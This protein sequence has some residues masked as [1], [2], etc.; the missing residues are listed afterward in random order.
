MG[1]VF[2]RSMPLKESL[3]RLEEQI[4]R[5][6]R[7]VKELTRTLRS[8]RRRIWTVSAIFVTATAAYAYLDNQ[9]MLL[10]TFGGTGLCYVGGYLLTRLYESRIRAVESALE[11]LRER[12][13]EQI[14]LLR[15]DECFETTKKLIDKYE[16]ESAKR[17][18]FSRVRQKERG[19]VDSVTD[20]VLGDDPSTT[21]ALICKKCHY[22]N[23]LVHPSEYDLMEFHCYN[24]NDLNVRTSNRRT[25]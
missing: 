19:I 24:C 9:S 23:G 4:V 14:E 5:E 25:E 6:E 15:K 3:M 8:L 17:D 2:S 10:F 16:G 20:L 13:K 18:Y 12:Q 11:V 21:Y 7:S 1:N 22:H